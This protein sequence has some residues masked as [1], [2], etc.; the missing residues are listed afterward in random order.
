MLKAVSHLTDEEL[1]ATRQLIRV[2][3][4][5]DKTYR[6]PYLSSML[7]FDPDMPAFFLY[8]EG[9]KLFGLLT[10]Y[11]DDEN[12]ELAI[13][14]HPDY[15]RKGIARQLFTRFQEETKS[16]PIA[17]ITF[18]T[19]RVFLE[20]NPKLIGHWNLVEDTE[21]ET[22]LG[23]DRQPYDFEIRSDVHVQLADNSHQDAIAQIHFEA[24][25]EPSETSEVS[26]RYIKEAL[27]DPN[28]LLYVLFKDNQL[29]ACCTV[30]LSSDMNYLY[31]LAVAE[32]FRG[33]G[34]GTYLVQNL[35]NDLIDKNTKTFQIAVNDDNQGAKHLYEKIGF[36]KQTE[37][38][39]LD[40]PK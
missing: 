33:Q 34:L 2:C 22:W 8:Y 26:Q 15:R 35:V 18:Q 14:V 37:V 9:Q 36:T 17:S 32:D 25:T 1:L 12:A 3:Q 28:S 31:G 20:K 21:T 16:Y 38:V 39:Y 4:A 19:E 27:K 10:V 7:N 30:D 24:F 23:R 5:H 11:A 29:V 6:D 40:S 13:L